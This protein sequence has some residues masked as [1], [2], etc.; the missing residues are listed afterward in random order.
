MEKFETRL[1]KLEEIVNKLETT[2]L[3]LDETLSLFKQGKELIKTLEND[4]QKA[5]NE[6]V[7]VTEESK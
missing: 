1:A 2:T 7:T 4:L 6:I 5:K 3:P